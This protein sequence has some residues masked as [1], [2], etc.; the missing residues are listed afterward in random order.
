[1][2]A[3]IKNDRFIIVTGRVNF[4]EDEEPKII[5]DELVEL[6]E[7]NISSKIT[8]KPNSSDEKRVSTKQQKVFIKIETIE[9]HVVDHILN[10]LSDY[11]GQVP[12]VIY[13]KKINGK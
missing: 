8:K 11:P 12:V 6:K 3:I 10:T 5:A 1:M 2:A 9:S 4:K 13:A 7:E